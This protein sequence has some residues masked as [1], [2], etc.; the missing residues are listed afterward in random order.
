MKDKLKFIF[1]VVHGCSKDVFTG[2][3]QLFEFVFP[4][5]HAE[6]RFRSF[7][8]ALPSFAENIT[9]HITRVCICHTVCVRLQTR[10]A[11]TGLYVQGV[12]T[13]IKL[14]A[15]ITRLNHHPAWLFAPLLARPLNETPIHP[16]AHP[17]SNTDSLGSWPGFKAHSLSPHT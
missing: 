10:Q 2:H 3:V 8:P 12:R 5:S 4:E 16:P 6:R 9:I 11:L 15:C 14:S 1:D 17:D 7:S 13:V